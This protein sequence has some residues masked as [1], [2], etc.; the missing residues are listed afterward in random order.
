MLKRQMFGRAKLDLL[1]RRLLLTS[2][3]G[4]DQV[5]GQQTLVEAPAWDAA[6]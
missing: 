5:P 4:Q 3:R 2:D 1:S 6:A